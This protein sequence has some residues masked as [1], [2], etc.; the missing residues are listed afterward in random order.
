M[1][2]TLL[3]VGKKM[4]D[5]VSAGY[6]EYARRLSGDCRL[7]LREVGQARGA[8]GAEIRE[9]EGKLLMENVPKGA[10]VVALDVLGQPWDTEKAADQLQ[11][12]KLMGKPICLLTG[13]PEGLSRSCLAIAAQRWSLSPLTFP[14][15]LVRI[16]VAEQ[17][18]R[19]NSLLN[20]HPYH[21]A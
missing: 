13:G 10:H 20:N 8:N 16:I 9:K 1:D 11:R 12:W 4:P 18:Y 17:I 6:N 15:P 5:W 19:A 21:R 2:I 14:H 7:V 3:A